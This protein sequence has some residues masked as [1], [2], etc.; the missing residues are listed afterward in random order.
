MEATAKVEN[1]FNLFKKR[2]YKHTIRKL[3]KWI[4]KASAVGQ[5]QN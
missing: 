2:G 4:L 1:Y 5:R 3:G